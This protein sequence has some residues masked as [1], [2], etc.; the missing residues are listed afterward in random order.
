MPVRI[1][2]QWGRIVVDEAQHVKNVAT[3]AAVLCRYRR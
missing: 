2:D 3:S 1:G